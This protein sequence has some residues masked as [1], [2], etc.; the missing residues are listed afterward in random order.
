M[1]STL[2]S[3]L[4]WFAIIVAAF[5]IYQYSSL[6]PRPT[7]MATSSDVAGA[8]YLEP[9]EEQACAVFRQGAVLL[10]VNQRGDM[11]TARLEGTKLT[12]LKGYGWEPGLTAEVKNAAK[13][14]AWRDGSVWTRK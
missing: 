14:I 4:F 6:Q 12:V 1:S 2:K 7:A 3:V 9:K 5:A 11:A 8:W 13:T 10:L